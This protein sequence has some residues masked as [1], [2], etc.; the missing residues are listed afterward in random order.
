MEWRGYSD[1]EM[2]VCRI[3][4]LA[5]IDC[6]CFC[7]P[8][9]IERCV[10]LR[11]VN[12]SDKEFSCAQNVPVFPEGGAACRILCIKGVDGFHYWQYFPLGTDRMDLPVLLAAAQEKV[13]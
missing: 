13:M 1:M 8:V 4:L 3:P 12:H 10:R 11:L 9:E 5:C 7:I 2:G 6:I